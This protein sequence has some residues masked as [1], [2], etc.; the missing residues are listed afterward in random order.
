V[1]TDLRASR[2]PDAHARNM[3]PHARP[4]CRH[5]LGAGTESDRPCVMKPPAGPLIAERPRYEKQGGR[6]QPRPRGKPTAYP[7]VLG[8]ASDQGK[9]AT[10]AGKPR[11]TV[12]RWSRSVPK[13]AQLSEAAHCW[14][15]EC[16]SKLL[17][18]KRDD[19]VGDGLPNVIG[20]SPTL[21]EMQVI[22]KAT[23]RARRRNARH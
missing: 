9:G 22:S 1:D 4:L 16:P 5:S 20:Q 12:L 11:L 23:P 17:R 3:R 10:L 18:N 6:P 2:G 15:Y 8:Y 14:G 7:L 19:L 21:R 13:P